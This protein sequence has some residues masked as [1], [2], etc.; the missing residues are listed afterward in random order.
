MISKFFKTPHQI[1]KSSY[2]F[3]STKQRISKEEKVDGSISDIV[4]TFMDQASKYTAISPAMMNFYKQCDNLFEVSIPF[5]RQ[6]GK[7]E[8][9]KGFRCQHKTHQLPTKGGLIISQNV[10]KQDIEAFACLNTIRSNTLHIPHGGAKG[11]IVLN[12]LDYTE[13]ELEMIIRKFTVECAKKG[14]IGS[15]IDIPGTDLGSTDREMNWIKDTY[16]YFYG[17]E[18]INSAACVTGKSL[19]QGGLS[20]S[21]ESSGFCVYFTLKHMLSQ[22]DFCQKAGI[23]KGLKG[24]TFIV[25]GYGSV[26]YWASHFLQE[27]GAK[28]VGVVERDGE[29]YNSD[30]ID[31]N[32]IQNYKVQNKGISGYPKATFQ[33]DVAFQ[34]CDI[35][36]PAFFAKS[37]HSENADKFNCKVI[38]EGANLSVTPNAEQILEKKGVQIIPDVIASSGGFL[39]GYFEWI[40]NISHKHHGSMTRKWE[41]KSN[42]QLLETIEVETGL[43]L[44][45]ILVNILWIYKEQ[46]K[47][48]KKNQYINILFQHDLV[49]SGLEE[50][51]ERSLN[52]SINTSKKLNVNLRIATYVNALTKLNIHY[53]QVGM[54]FSK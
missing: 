14:I 40:K 4:Y 33:K 15:S 42:I 1:Y 19:N 47:Y 32:D 45:N 2:H 13:R 53:S 46:L 30:G 25:E 5:Q 20:G 54:T 48:K 22:D 39:S 29:I 44:K 35:F 9:I 23:Q 12:P 6:D 50:S 11:A 16:T 38:A 7:L 26:G 36:I 31:A 41:Q 3:T 8:V 21:Q 52:E 27:A 24:K 17:K 10:I 49:E 34:K 51:Y 28:L 43:K 37:I 18:D